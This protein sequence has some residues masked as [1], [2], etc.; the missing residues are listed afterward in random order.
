MTGVEFGQVQSQVAYSPDRCMVWLRIT[1]KA[2]RNPVQRE[3]V[4]GA[5]A[6][7]TA[8]QAHASP[9]SGRRSRSKST[10]QLCIA[11]SER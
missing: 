3:Y 6:L 11:Q 5:R 9:G 4:L 10:S 7:K 8:Q 1:G 2:V